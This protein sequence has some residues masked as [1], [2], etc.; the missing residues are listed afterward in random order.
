MGIQAWRE[1]P[2]SF[3][4]E[5]G[6][7][8]T[9]LFK[10]YVMTLDDNALNGS[11]PLT[12]DQIFAAT[13]LT[14]GVT[15]WDSVYLQYKPRK[16]RI[17]EAYEG[18]PYEIL[19]TVSFGIVDPDELIAP[20]S[21]AATWQV[22]SQTIEVPALYYFDGS[23]NGTKRPLMNSANDYFQGLTTG[24]PIARMRWFKNIAATRASS[25]AQPYGG[26]PWNIVNAQNSVNNAAWG[27]NL[28]HTARVENVNV[29]YEEEEFDGL[30]YNIWKT[31]VIIAI[32]ATSWNLQLPDVGFNYLSGGQKRRAMV[33]D[34][35][36][37]E[38][39]PSPNPVGLD[40]SGNQ[41]NGVPAVLNRRVCPEANFTSLFGAPPS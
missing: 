13:G 34:N 19:V 40:G 14:F 15:A 2:R 21:R 24:E 1:L 35:E 12:V 11:Q 39:I 20:T 37:G 27:S 32:R 6:K 22:E 17:E 38:W 7:A 29:E 23:G 5:V 41:T 4:R 10:R 8:P 33:R 30:L 9:E 25:G 28:V 18:N 3:E 16:V 31:T 26:F 36:N